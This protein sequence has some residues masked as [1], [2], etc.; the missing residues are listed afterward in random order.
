VR[1]LSRAGLLVAIVCALGLGCSAVLGIT[2]LPGL[3]VGLEAG[4]PESG[5]ES[6]SEASAD[7]AVDSGG[8]DGSDAPAPDATPEAASVCPLADAA[9]GE[10]AEYPIPMFN[11]VAG[12]QSIPD[13]IAFGPDGNL[14]FT[15]TAANAVGRIAPGGSISQL[16]M[17]PPAPLGIV[18][19]PQGA[20]W[21][22]A[23]SGSLGYVVAAG[24]GSSVPV[25][26]PIPNGANGSPRRIAVGSDGNL[27]FTLFSTNMIGTYNP[28]DGGFVEYPVPTA[29]S[30]PDG[31]TAGPPGDGN[32]WF[33]EEA[34]DKIGAMAPDGTVH[35]YPIPTT[36]AMAQGITVGPDGALWFAEAAPA[37]IGRMTTSGAVV[38]YPVGTG[39]APKHVASDGRA[40]WFTEG[41]T[42][43]IG[44][45]ALD[46]GVTEYQAPTPGAT[47]AG[48]AIGPCGSVWFG[49]YNA[50]KIGVLTP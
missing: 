30:E 26:M 38:E 48:I 49:E 13:G 45:I 34:G 12:N 40:V 24:P 44:R 14:W 15:A 17:T 27:W 50:G 19:G 3:G 9:V 33:T 20:V 32:V 28:A 8:F 16:S 4:A 18:R 2:D 42:N 36:G 37:Q 47:P 5:V 1:R 43:K 46:G 31:I 35:E 23:S 39:S 6:G 21:F 22:V 25:T 11:G 7:G 41:D 29:N 10:I